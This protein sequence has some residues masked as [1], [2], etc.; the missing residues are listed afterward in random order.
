MVSADPSNSAA[1]L[2]PATVRPILPQDPAKVGAQ[3]PDG[4]QVVVTGVRPKYERHGGLAKTGW[5]G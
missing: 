5:R 2:D 4:R 1:P 3:H